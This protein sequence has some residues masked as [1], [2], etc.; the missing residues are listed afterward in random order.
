MTF[1]TRHT[2]PAFYPSMFDAY[3]DV[4]AILA[5]MD[6]G[7]EVDDPMRARIMRAL[8][9]CRGILQLSIKSGTIFVTKDGAPVKESG[10]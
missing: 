7:A 2:A 6:A 1:G 10:E 8:R 3:D 4:V 5:Q 9:H